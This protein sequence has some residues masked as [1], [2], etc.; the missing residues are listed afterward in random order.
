[1][2]SWTNET[3]ITLAVPTAGALLALI[4]GIIGKTALGWILFILGILLIAAALYVRIKFFKEMFETTRL[5]MMVGGGAVLLLVLI[6]L[7]IMLA[8]S[9]RAAA[10]AQM[11][12]EQ[13]QPQATILPT[14]VPATATTAVIPTSTLEPTAI[15][16]AAPAEPIF[17]CLNENARWGYRPRMAPRLD[18]EFGG[19][20]EWGSCFTV[21]AKAAGYPG[22]YH[23][24][25]GQEGNV[26]GVSIGVDEVLFPLWIEGTYLES[27]GVN[28]DTLP[29]M[30]VPNK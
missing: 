24:T 4:G 1:M 22:W 10:P 29:E 23:L 14:K 21:D 13:L 18:A 11:T 30:E 5:W 2:R 7:I 19:D 16:T 15:A 20:I 27:F 6:G 3:W 12:T 17:V 9:S 25:V 28:L 8:S 26:I